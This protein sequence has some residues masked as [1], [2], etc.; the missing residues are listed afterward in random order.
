[1]GGSRGG[2]YGPSAS[3]DGAPSHLNGEENSIPIHF[4]TL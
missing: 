3:Y 4:I 2:A 1:M